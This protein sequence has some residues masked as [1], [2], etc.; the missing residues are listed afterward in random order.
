MPNYFFRTMRKASPLTGKASISIRDDCFRRSIP[1][2]PAPPIT[3]NRTLQRNVDV[4]DL[5]VFKQLVRGLLAPHSGLLIATERRPEKVSAH[6]ID[7]HEA[8]FD[9]GRGPVRCLEIFGPDRRRQ[10][11]IHSIDRL[12]H[13]VLVTPFEHR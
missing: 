12:K 9:T 1:P 6:G 13:L 4:F 3:G 5:S 11:I 7:P 10:A 8:H 2:A